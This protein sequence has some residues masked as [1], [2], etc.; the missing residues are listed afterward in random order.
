MKFRSHL[1]DIA[2]IFLG[3]LSA[4]MGLKGFILPSHFIDGGVTGIS[5][6]LANVT[7]LPLSVLIFIIN[8]P[9]LY[10]GYRKLG[11]MFALKSTSA[12][13]GYRFV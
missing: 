10:L 11:T 2:L 13:A 4:G 5:I 3:I 1:I 7:Q 9:F 12:I 8:V 6:L